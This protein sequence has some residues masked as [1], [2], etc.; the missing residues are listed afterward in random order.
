MSKRVQLENNVGINRVLKYEE[1]YLLVK[2]SSEWNLLL[3]A[4]HKL[5]SLGIHNYYYGFIDY[6]KSAY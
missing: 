5:N 2:S 1:R 4:F 3:F 6:K